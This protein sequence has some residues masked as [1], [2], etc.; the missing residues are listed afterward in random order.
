MAAVLSFSSMQRIDTKKLLV[1][2]VAPINFKKHMTAKNMKSSLWQLTAHWPDDAE[3]FWGSLIAHEN[4]DDLSSPTQEHWEND[5]V[6]FFMAA[7][8]HPA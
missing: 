6:E 8:V 4:A 3:D 2:P 5:F 1:R 7:A